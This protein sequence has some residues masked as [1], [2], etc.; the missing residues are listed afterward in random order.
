MKTTQKI[1]VIIFDFGGVLID[2]SPYFLY[3]KVM[4]DDQQ[5]DR[6]SVV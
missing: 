5:I 1:P 4:K 3:R 2:W 6:K